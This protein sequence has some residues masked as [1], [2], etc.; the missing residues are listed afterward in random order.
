MEVD[1]QKET[2]SKFD[3]LS[4]SSKDLLAQMM[5]EN[6]LKRPSIDEVLTHDWMISESVDGLQES[7]FFEMQARTDEI[8]HTQKS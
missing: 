3:F 8:T 7:V 5:H 2:Y 4:N 6:P 1:N